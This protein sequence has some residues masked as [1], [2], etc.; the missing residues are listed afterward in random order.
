MQ[1]VEALGDKA[2]IG[3]SNNI[4]KKIELRQDGKSVSLGKEKVKSWLS[5]LNL[6]KWQEQLDHQGGGKV[7][8]EEDEEEEKDLVD[9]E[10]QSQFESLE[11]EQSSEDEKKETSIPSL[12][13]GGSRRSKTGSG[14]QVI[15]LTRSQRLARQGV[16]KHLPT[17]SGEPEV[18]PLFISSFEYTTE[19]CGFTNIDNLKRLQD[20]LQGNALEAVRSRLVLPDSVPDVIED[21]RNLFG[22]P[23]KLLKTLMLKVRNAPSPR[24][25]RLESFIHF[26]IAVKQLCDHLLAAGLREHCNNPML[27]DELVEKLPTSYKLDWVRYKR[28]KNATTLK[29]FSAF[30]QDIVSD[31][32]E[33]SDFSPWSCN[34]TVRRG[35]NKSRQ[36]FVHLHD[37][38][39]KPEEGTQI[40]KA[41][42]LCW[43]CKSDDHK[44]RYCDEFKQM[45]VAERLSAVEKLKLC[46]ICLNNH[47]KSRCNAKLRCTM[48][49]CGGNHHYLLHRREESMQLMEVACNSHKNL[50]CGVIFRM[51][52]VKLTVGQ[53]SIQTVAFLDEGS[54]STLIDE[55]MAN[56]LKAKGE[57]E[58]L[59]VKWT[60]DIRRHENNS[61]KIKLELSAIGENKKFLLR[62]VRTVSELVLPKQSVRFAEISVRYP[63]LAGLSVTDHSS[64]EPAILIGLDN[65]HL[66][67][68]LESRVGKGDEPIAGR[69]KLGWTIYGP[70]QRKSSAET[71]LNLHSVTQASN[72]EL[73]DMI[74]TQ[75]TLDEAGVTSF[76]VPESAEDQRARAILQSTTTRIGNRFQTGLLWRED[77]RQFPDSYSMAVRRM[78]ALEKRLEKDPELKQNVYKQI[79][80]Y[81]VKGYAHKVMPLKVVLNPRKP[82]KVRLVW[83]ASAAVNGVS[84]NSELLKGPD[85][86][87]SLPGVLCSFRER[88]IAYGGD[89]A[90][91]YHQIHV[92]SEDKSAQRFL[93]RTSL[94]ETPQVYVMD[95]LTFEAYP[96]AAKAVINRHYVDDYYDSADT[97]EDAV[98][99]AKEVQHIHDQGGFHIRNWVSN[100]SAF[101]E[102][103]VERKADK[104]VRFDQ[105]TSTDY[106]RILGIV[107]TPKQDVFV[108][109]T[110]SNIGLQVIVQS[111]ERPTKRKVL[112]CVMALFDPLGL[113]S[114]FTVLGR[115]LI[116]DIW[117]TGCDWDDLID[118][119]SY[120]KWTCW[121]RLISDIERF[122]IPRAYFGK[123]KTC[124]IEDIQLH[125]FTDASETAYGCVAYLRAVIKGEVK[126]A[127]VMSRSKVA[128]LKQL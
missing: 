27:I 111:D 13:I 102:K 29:T 26:G 28:G 39:Q 66:F 36:E 33:V 79:S 68:P 65:L 12:S 101:L 93:F 59:I 77:E 72:Q 24:I 14:T 57:A 41:S 81:Q 1:K 84:L 20:C 67:A 73:H 97:V 3:R 122:K 100:S 52:P 30:M 53:I 10:L 58:P 121:L 48:K 89:I 125:I 105:D 86:L 21:L 46:G 115:M 87:V 11:E 16:S 99:I 104:I 127:L 83:D 43:I 70:Q 19:A 116:Q 25:E 7:A 44:I 90:E 38:I 114:P 119:A 9:E 91:M 69:S 42:K 128:P 15:K 23:Q 117:R 32:S 31:I 94:D 60:G 80:E 107:W 75:Y 95:V 71:F 113:L 8:E 118:D 62:D 54:S 47:G 106:E 124:E 78:K 120:H 55:R 76:G 96:D 92:R 5:E 17:F 103:I 74:R 110:S 88:P 61:R 63:H 85:M 109:A 82:N 126:C 37:G 50:Y 56:R 51:V 40:A 34:E 45:S 123:A 35:K 64:E 18:W 112:R 6:K 22:K 4:S 108:F 98:R 2:A 49:N